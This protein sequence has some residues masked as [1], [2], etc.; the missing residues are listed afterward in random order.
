MLF[1]EFQ[2]KYFTFLLGKFQQFWIQGPS[3]S[4]SMV[5]LK[6]VN[7]SGFATFSEYD[8]YFHFMFDSRHSFNKTTTALELS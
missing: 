3:W 2:L 6:Q 4:C 1:F 8:G 5:V 7:V